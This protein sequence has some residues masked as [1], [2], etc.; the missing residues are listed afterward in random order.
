[1]ATVSEVSNEVSPVSQVSTVRKYWVLF[2]VSLTTF[3]VFVEGSVIN[4]ALPSIAREFAATNSTLQW[5][6]NS[7]SLLVAGLLLFGGTTGDRFGRR[8]LLAIGAVI[9]GGAAVGAALSPNTTVLIIMRG[10]QGVGAAFM[11]PSTLSIITDVF[12][13]HERAKAIAVWTAVGGMGAG[14]GPVLGGLL[15]D[16]LSWEAVFWLHLP[17][18]ATILIGLSLVPESRD[19][20]QT[21]MDLPGAILGTGGLLAVVYAIIQGPESGWSSAEIIS[22][23]ALGVVLLVAFAFVEARSSHPML[24]V[25]Y[26]T[27]PGFIGPAMVITVL[28]IAMAGVFFFT[29]QFLQLV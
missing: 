29:T 5:V 16:H 8:R 28:V 12:E 25:H 24:P 17:L 13:R 22:S 27:Q 20:R 6:V 11:L 26:L 21:P 7:Y 9:F 19:S 4:T 15:V 1:M 2:V 14:L 10:L 18:V 3:M 23:F